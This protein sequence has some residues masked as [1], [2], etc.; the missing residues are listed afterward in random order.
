[1][2]CQCPLTYVECEFSDAGCNAK[3]YRK[4]LTSHL[5][6]NLVTHMSLLVAENGNL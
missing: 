5:T 4:D 6:D 2:F 1:M 3:V